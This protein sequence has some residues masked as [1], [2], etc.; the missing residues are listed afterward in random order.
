MDV[1]DLGIMHR[2]CEAH[3]EAR[4]SPERMDPPLFEFAAAQRRRSRKRRSIISSMSRRERNDD[5]KQDE[6]RAEGR[7]P[8]DLFLSSGLVC[9]LPATR[10]AALAVFKRSCIVRAKRTLK[11]ALHPNGWIRLRSSSPPLNDVD[12]KPGGPSPLQFRSGR[13][14]QFDVR[15][16]NRSS[17]Q[18]REDNLHLSSSV[19]RPP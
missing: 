18:E 16:R 5:W 11:R 2:P 7:G 19:R 12:L 3:A 6:D 17:A 9:G 8:Q 14:I 1:T 15:K 13:D 4:T 10:A